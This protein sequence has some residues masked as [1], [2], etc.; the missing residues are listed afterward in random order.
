MSKDVAVII[1]AAGKSTRM[2]SDVPKVLHPVCARPMLGYVL[3]L[4]GSLNLKISIAVLGYKHQEVRKALRPG[5]KTVIQKRLLG[6][7]DAVKTALP[8]LKNFKGTVLILYADNPLVKKETIKNLLKSHRENKADVTLLTAE[9]THPGGY[10]RILRDEYASICGI[11][12]EKDADD[13]QRDIKEINTGIMCF[14]KESLVEAL[15][16]VRPDNRKKEYYLTDTIGILYKKGRLI[17]AARLADVDEALG[18]NSR[19]DLAKAGAVM[20]SRINEKLMEEGVTIVSPAATIIGFGAK[21]GRDTTIYPFTVIESDV[22]IGR[23]CTIGPFSHVRNG[24]R[25]EDGVQIGNFVELVRSKLGRQ[26]LVKHFG[27]IGD[28]RIGSQVNI[29]AGT[30]TANFDGKKKNVTIIKDKVFIGSDTVLV[31]PVTVG[32]GALTGAGSVV[33]KNM[34]VPDGTAVA[35]VPARPIKK[36]RRG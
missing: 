31:A 16:A 25:I 21:V 8:L 12:E 30:V 6:T 26:T 13:F 9:L 32:R 1:L 11:I 24:S 10:G 5:I 36:V 18:I 17:D 23:R 28:S 7:A 4:V 34:H 29:G 3:D 15:K 27:Y 14:K 20:Q 2:K 22:T 19:A 33:L 35:G